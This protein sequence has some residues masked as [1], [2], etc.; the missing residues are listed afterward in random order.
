MGCIHVMSDSFRS[1]SG[2]MFFEFGA[3]SLK[4]HWRP[5]FT[6]LWRCRSTIF[7]GVRLTG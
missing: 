3:V 7:I 4:G 2:I 1:S 6:I 5:A